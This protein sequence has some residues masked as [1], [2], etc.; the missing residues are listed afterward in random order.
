MKLSNATADGLLAFM[1][2]L[3][4]VFFE[5][6]RGDVLFFEEGVVNGYGAESDR[7]LG[8]NAA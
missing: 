8:R 2:R 7:T 1:I 6:A 3:L 4:R 5:M